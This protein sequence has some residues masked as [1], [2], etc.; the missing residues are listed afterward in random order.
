MSL[1]IGVVAGL[2]FFASMYVTNPAL[3]CT[4]EPNHVYVVD[5]KACLHINAFVPAQVV[6]P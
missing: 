5:N 6:L 3:Q 2:V 4:R 1:A